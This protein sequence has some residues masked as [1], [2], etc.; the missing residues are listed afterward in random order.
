MQ[1]LAATGALCATRAFAEVKGSPVSWIL[2]GTGK[3]EGIYRARWDSTTGTLGTPELA[4]ATPQPS[5]LTLHPHLP[6][7][8]A[9][10]EGDVPNASIT[11]FTLDRNA[12][13]LKPLATQPTHGS[14]PC[15]VS[16]DHTAR[17]LFAANYSGGSLA[18]FALDKDGLPAPAARVFECA[19]NTACGSPGPVK[20]RQSGPHLHCATISP[21]NRFV[22]ACD[23]GDDSILVFPI[24][25][26][27]AELLGQPQRI[28]T[29]AGAGPRHL[30]FHPNGR[31]LYCINELG[32]SVVLYEWSGGKAP[33]AQ[34][35]AGAT[36]SVLPPHAQEGATSTGA[37]IAL[38]RDGRF[39]YTSTRFSDVLTVFSIDSAN[40]KLA[41]LQQLACGGKTP[42]FFALDPTERWLV[43][44]NQDSND[45]TVFARNAKTG[46]LTSKATY[47]ATNPQ[48]VLWV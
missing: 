28:P 45:I 26:G 2:L 16:L 39:A 27:A 24:Q 48:C 37:E 33:H 42:R 18:A 3:G 5:Y 41:Q 40:G 17:L 31:W 12:A 22:L 47:P 10:N 46:Q 36:V 21:D 4:A 19:G 9:C 15:F 20:D 35:V 34:A 14:A 38:T 7:V 1:G 6:V 13:S 44:A 29:G 11:A 23:L 30:A 32:C 25:P 43:C 8:Y